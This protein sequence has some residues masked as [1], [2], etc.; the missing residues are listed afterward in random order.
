MK[1]LVLIAAMLMVF[2]MVTLAQAN[3]LIDRG[4]GLIY[5]SDLDITWLQDAGLG[6]QKTWDAAKTWAEALNYHDTVRDVYYDDWRLP[7]ALYEELGTVLTGSE[8][9]HLYYEELGNAAF[10][11]TVNTSPFINLTNRYW[12]SGSTTFPTH[13]YYFN[14]SNGNQGRDIKTSTSYAAWA[15]RDG[16]IASPPPP[17]PPPPGVPEPT[18][19]LLLGLG[20]M[21]VAG[22]RRRMKM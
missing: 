5:D 14:F 9:G 12:T 4:G 6:G 2:V 20:L 15:V 18:T 10:P 11:L 21:G 13:A 16:D 7:T 19:M 1:K 17:P 3:N 8:M 22:I